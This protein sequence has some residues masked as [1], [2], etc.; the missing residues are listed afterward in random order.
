MKPLI[1]IAG[2]T[3]SGKSGVAV[4]LAKR[5]NGAIV[6][7]DS[8]Q[9]YRNMDIGTAKIKK[10]EMKGVDHYLLNIIEP[11]E[12]FSIARFQE[13]AKKAVDEI[14]ARGQVPI[15]AGGTG[16]YIQSVTRDVDFAEND[17]DKTYRFSLEAFVE[18]GGD[19]ARE[20]L[21]EQL[22]EIDPVSGVNIHPNNIKRVIRALEYYHQTG[23]TISAH[24]DREKQK[25]AA[26]DLAFYVLDMER[27]TLYKRINERVDAMVEEGLVSEVKT[28]LDKGFDKSLVSMQGLGYKEIIDYLDGSYD[29]ETAVEILKRD[30]R[31]FAKR[32]LTWFK[33]EEEASWIRLESFDFNLEAVAEYIVKDIEERHIL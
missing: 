5:I 32:Q 8:M 4:A 17:E 24:N 3:A 18:K 2:P 10:E 21:H 31:R 33:R 26:Y 7:G 22:K 16:F 29:I 6:S 27:D 13:Y 19:E 25:P 14:H 9:V 1:V 30:T 23:E 28:L 11:D 15:L 12:P 20:Q